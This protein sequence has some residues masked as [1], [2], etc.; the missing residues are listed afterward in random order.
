MNL[1][2]TYELRTAAVVVAKVLMIL[3]IVEYGLIALLGQTL[4]QVDSTS[5]AILDVALLSGISAP[6][7]YLWVI[8]P[9]I[10]D[11]HEAVTQAN[12]LA[13]HDSLTGLPNRR[14]VDIHLHQTLHDC[15]RSHQHAALVMIDLNNFK[16]INENYGHEAGDHALKFVSEQINES[17]RKVD[18]A[19]RTGGDE[20]M[21]IL[22][23]L[24]ATIDNASAL[25]SQIIERTHEHIE[26][27]FQWDDHTFELSASIGVRIIT[28]EDDLITPIVHDADIAMFEAKSD[29]D[30]KSVIFSYRMEEAT[31]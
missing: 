27:A 21:L 4:F 22:M 20:F 14:L 26:R 25:V 13:L 6:I 17:I 2:S 1:D 24:G 7:T 8:R 18:I 3:A 23:N 10:L 30:H 12:H 29:D 16:P 9:F 15:A 5:S 31:A 11:R 19:G 28:P